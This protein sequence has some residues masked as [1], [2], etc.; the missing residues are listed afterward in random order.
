MLTAITRQVS[1]S[2][3]KCEL[4]HLER[5]PIDFE[6]AKK[7][8]EKYEQALRSLG[9][10]V[11]SLPV[12]TALPDSVFVEDIAIV[13]DEYGV[14]TRPG[15][16]S[17]RPEIPSISAALSLFRKLVCLKEPAT[18]DGGDVLVIGKT[19]YVGLSLRS[20]Q[21]ALTQLQNMLNPYGYSIKGVRVNG[22]LHLK[23]AVT[24]VAEDTLLI[25]PKWVDK[26]DFPGFG[27]IEIHPAESFAANALLIGKVVIYPNLFP[28]TQSRLESAGI[29]VNPVDVSEIVKAEGAVTCCSLVFNTVG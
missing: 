17:R 20:N 9:V 1:P 7:Q 11:I 21:K 8:H 15:A 28:N 10:K 5:Q 25:N 16:D 23:S 13:L 12:Q 2:I 18:L 4:T 27:F 22:C 19:I 3:N 29:R 24:Q 26:M 6:L 14:I